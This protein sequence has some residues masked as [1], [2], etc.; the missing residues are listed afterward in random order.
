L[1]K[2]YKLK[3]GTVVTVSTTHTYSSSSGKAPLIMD[4]ILRCRWMVSFTQWALELVSRLWRREKYLNS[5]V[6]T[7]SDH[8]TDK[9][10]HTNTHSDLLH[11]HG[12]FISEVVKGLWRWS[13][14]HCVCLCYVWT[15]NLSE[16]T[17]CD[18]TCTVNNM[19]RSV[20]E[21]TVTQDH[22]WL[23]LSDI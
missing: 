8:P 21:G 17:F 7:I 20:R 14:T 10:T 19:L 6:N 3:E 2:G 15:V 18:W 22:N 5:A 4:L 9:H 12:L 13:R 23:L 16:F 1:L 11:F